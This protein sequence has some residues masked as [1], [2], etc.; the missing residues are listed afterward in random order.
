MNSSLGV[1]IALAAHALI[2]RYERDPARHA[3]FRLRA[4]VL[5]L[6][7]TIGMLS[8]FDRLLR[9]LKAVPDLVQQLAYGLVAHPDAVRPE[10]LP[11]EGDSTLRTPLQRGL[12]IASGRGID[13]PLQR[14]QELWI[15][16]LVLPAAS[17][18]PT[19][20]D[21]SLGLPQARSS[22]RPRFTV[23][24][25]SPVARETAAR[26]PRPIAS[27]SAPAHRRVMRSSIEAASAANFFSMRASR[28]TRTVG[29]DRAILLI[30]KRSCSINF[31]IRGPS[32]TPLRDA[33]FETPASRRPVRD[34][35][36][37]TPHRDARSETP[38]PRRPH[39]DARTETPAPRRPLRDAR[40]ATAAPSRDSGPA[41]FILRGPA[42]NQE[43]GCRPP[44]CSPLAACLGMVSDRHRSR[45][46]LTSSRI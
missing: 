2:D 17:A 14:G 12:G 7:V 11:R 24:R 16:V 3:L 31:R 20:I 18:L 43:R 41:R 42:A 25:A 45:R 26:P 38:A 44:A 19:H 13:E 29:H 32:E 23:L 33:R 10:Q 46:R 1:W 34:A 4:D 28:V 5:E 36:I 15:P 30:V 37:E 27:A 35:R 39:R 9:R 40:T 8:A 21:D 6:R 22:F